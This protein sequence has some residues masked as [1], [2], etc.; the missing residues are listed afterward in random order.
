VPR[1]LLQPT[2]TRLLS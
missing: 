2:K 1:S